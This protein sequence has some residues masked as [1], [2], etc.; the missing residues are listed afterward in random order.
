MHHTSAATRHS[1]NELDS[2]HHASDSDDATDAPP[3]HVQIKVPLAM[4]DF[5]HCDPKRCSGKKLARLGL[6]RTLKV[7]QR[8]PGIILTPEGKRAIS[9]LDRAIVLSHGLCVVEA[10]WARLDEVPFERIRSPHDRLLPFL[11]ASNP[12]NY[13]RPWKLN[14]DYG[15][16]LM[17]RFTWGH[18]FYELNE[19]LFEKYA[20]CKDSAEV[21][22]VQN[23]Y[24]KE[25]E[26][27]QAAQKQRRAR[28]TDNGAN[29]DDLFVNT[30]RQASIG[31][32]KHSRGHISSSSSSDSDSDSD[33][34]TGP[35]PP[36][37]K[38]KPTLSQ[39]DLPPAYSDDDHDD[40]SDSDSTHSPQKPSSTAL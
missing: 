28:A 16:E 40:D 25:L 15:D 39:D 14:C 38:S 19:M 27:E 5:A 4:W 37:H 12:V 23:E 11:V 34:D 32:S 2:D 17:S 22:A 24:I 7:S 36:N 20:A 33:S 1:D 8:F 13:G 29:D 30:N 9:P 3:A 35:S 21:V 31:Y 10:S 26:D 18:A 6:I